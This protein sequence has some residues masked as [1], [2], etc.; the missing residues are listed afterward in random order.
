MN[1]ELIENLFNA[2]SILLEKEKEE[3][4]KKGE[5][6]NVFSILKMEFKENDTHSAFLG[7]L[8]NPNG[9]HL[10]GSLFLKLFLD[11]IGATNI[12]A[13]SVE[14]VLEK[15]IGPVFFDEKNPLD[16]RGGRIDI[17]L[18][19]ANRN[20]ISIENKINAPEQKLQVVRYYNFNKI[21]NKVYYL[22]LNGEH[23]SEFST[24]HLI[25]NEDY[26]EINYAKTIISWLEKCLNEVQDSSILKG[27][28]RQYVILLQK[29]T[30]NMDEKYKKDL[31]HH[32]LSNYEVVDNIMLNAEEARKQVCSGIY[33]DFFIQLKKELA[34]KKELEVILGNNVDHKHSQIWIKPFNQENK[35]LWVVI[36]SFSG[37][38][39]LGGDLFIGILN[40]PP[41]KSEYRSPPNKTSFSG[42]II[43]K[44]KFSKKNGFDSNLSNSKTI[45]KIYTEEIFRKEFVNHLVKETLE[46]IEQELPNLELFIRTGKL[47]VN[48][49]LSSKE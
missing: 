24:N 10:K 7:E 27:S 29:L 18:E 20:S 15:Y 21:A 17:Y 9:N 39:H 44:R 38:G 25:S 36:E 12:D 45:Q 33:N 19:D 26:I 31:I 37:R 32:I 11:E 14:V 1:I 16:S 23:P 35:E 28:I 42:W 4:I 40:P 5:K 8:L 47:P 3:E 30:G 6:F 46:Y 43:N 13:E 34:T 41:H 2:V 22:T 48:H 49:D